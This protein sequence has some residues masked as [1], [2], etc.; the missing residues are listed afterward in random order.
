[1][2]FQFTKQDIGIKGEGTEGRK[3]VAIRALDYLPQPALCDR[4]DGTWWDRLWE[5]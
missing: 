2:L 1:M 3:P 4:A 5:Y